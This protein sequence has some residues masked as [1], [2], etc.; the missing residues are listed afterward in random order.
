MF[1]NRFQRCTGKLD[2]YRLIVRDKRRFAAVQTI[3]REKQL[4]AGKIQAKEASK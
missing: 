2:N 3:L 1:N 4:A